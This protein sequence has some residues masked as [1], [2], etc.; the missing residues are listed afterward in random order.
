[1]NGWDSDS[2]VMVRLITG[3]GSTSCNLYFIRHGWG[4]K[5]LLLAASEQSDKRARLLS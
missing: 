3:A 4:L 5:R 1:M 2:A